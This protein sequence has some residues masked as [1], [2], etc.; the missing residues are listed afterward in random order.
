MGAEMSAKQKLVRAMDKLSCAMPTEERAM[1]KLA[2]AMEK[3]VGFIK[4]L[5]IGKPRAMPPVELC[6]P[7]GAVCWWR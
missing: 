7:V 1:E 6:C 2:G 3:E 5:G 4:V